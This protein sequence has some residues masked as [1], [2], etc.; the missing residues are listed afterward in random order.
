MFPRT[1][2]RRS[3]EFEEVEKVNAIRSEIEDENEEGNDPPHFLYLCL[4]PSKWKRVTFESGTQD[5]YG[6]L[7]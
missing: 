5:D 1:C 6:F 7:P 2:S 4:K 3:S